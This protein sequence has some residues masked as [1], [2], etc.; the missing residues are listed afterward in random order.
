MKAVLIGMI[1]SMFSWQGWVL[2]NIHPSDLEMLFRVVESEAT[3]GTIEQKKNV[4]SCVLARMRSPEFPNTVEGVI[5]EKGQ[6]AVI[7]DKRYYN[8]KVTESTKKAVIEVL[9]CGMTTDC[10]F[11]CTPTCQS[12]ETGWFSTLEIQFND[13]MHIYTYG[14][15]KEGGP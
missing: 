14:N 10:L 5:F 2:N 15:K 3:G 13:K 6:F 11:F 1:A 9:L 12:A 4:M 7:S 8:V